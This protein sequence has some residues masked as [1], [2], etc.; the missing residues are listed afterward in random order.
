MPEQSGDVRPHRQL[1]EM[2]VIL[3]DCRS[4]ESNPP[5]AHSMLR[6]AGSL[7]G[8][9]GRRMFSRPRHSEQL[10]ITIV[11]AAMQ[12][13][14]LRGRAW[15]RPRHRNGC[16]CPACRASPTGRGRRSRVPWRAA[17]CAADGPH[18]A[19]GDRD[20]GRQAGALAPSKDWPLRITTSH[21]AFACL[22]VVCV[23][24]ILP[25]PSNAASHLSPLV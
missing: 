6:R 18:L 2:L 13:H 8:R 21:V 4:R 10:P 11:V 1:I 15:P 24:Q 9:T 16:E 17:I 20:V 3:A 12:P 5:A 7:P 22:S 25:P 14:H 19:I 23:T